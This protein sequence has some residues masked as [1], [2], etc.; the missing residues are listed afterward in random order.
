MKYGQN[1]YIK[2]LNRLNKVYKNYSLNLELKKQKQFITE[3]SLACVD[4]YTHVCMDD[5]VSICMCAYVVVNRCMCGYSC[6]Y[7]Q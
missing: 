3:C 4:P 5:C 7:A 2:K 6:V 1:C